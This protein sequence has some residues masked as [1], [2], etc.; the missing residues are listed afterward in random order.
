VRLNV[1]EKPAYVPK[2][3]TSISKKGKTMKNRQPRTNVY[4]Y[5]LGSRSAKALAVAVGGKVLKHVGSKFR[6]RAEDTVIN[7]GASNCPEFGGARVLNQH[8]ETAQCKLKAFEAMGEA[9]V[10][11]PSYEVE[12]E[13]AKQLHFPVV[14]RTKLRGHSGDGIVIA[15][16]MADLVEAPLYTQY[17]KKKDE[18]RVH[19]V[20]GM[21]KCE[22]FFIQR[23]ARKLENENPD[24][25]VRNLAGGFVFVEEHIDDVPKDVITQAKKAIDALGLDFGGV[26]VIWNEHEGKAYVLECNTACGLEERT[27]LHYAD[28]LNR[29]D[30]A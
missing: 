6:P 26:D 1:P 18:Y 2:Q 15:Q 5:K 13:Y 23:K 19:I 9:G 20:D 30:E 12:L 7:W 27:A 3:K 14:C 4:P 22:A 11:I 21:Y 29:I 28:A 25:Q 17:V 24:W 8:T 16:V 10:R